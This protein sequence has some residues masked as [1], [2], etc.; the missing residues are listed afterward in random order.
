MES[1]IG[2]INPEQI[3]GPLSRTTTDSL[4]RLR[5]DRPPV[6]A[7]QNTASTTPGNAWNALAVSATAEARSLARHL[8]RRGYQ[9]P[10]IIA[11]KGAKGDQIL[12]SFSNTWNGLQRYQPRVAVSRYDPQ[13][14]GTAIQALSSGLQFNES[15]QRAA[16]IERAL[17]Q[18]VQSHSHIRSDIDVILFATDNST[19]RVLVPGLRYFDAS[20][21][22]HYGFSTTWDGSKNIQHNQDLDGLKIPVMPWLLELDN[23]ALSELSQ[24]GV[25]PSIELLRL[26]ALGYDAWLVST[27]LRP[28]ERQM[29]AIKGKTGIISQHPTEGLMIAPEWIQMQKGIPRVLKYE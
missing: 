3:I 16:T 9:R 25:P 18:K 1:V 13:Q 6:L 29:G 28:F 26:Y 8:A 14:R 4:Y 2:Q 15:R 10:L 12:A 5:I 22:P 7:L 24:K 11:P 19:A 27:R 17:G 23:K 20:H 21:I